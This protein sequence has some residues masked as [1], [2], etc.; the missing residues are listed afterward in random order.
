MVAAHGKQAP[1]APF[2]KSGSAIRK[3]LATMCNV[4]PDDLYAPP[5]VSPTKKASRA[6]AEG[7]GTK[8]TICTDWFL[9]HLPLRWRG[10]V[11]LV[12]HPDGIHAIGGT[13]DV[14]PWL[15]FAM[16]ATGV[17]A[18]WLVCALLV[19]TSLLPVFVHEVLRNK[20]WAWTALMAVGA[21]LGMLVRN[22]AARKTDLTLNEHS[23]LRATIDQSQARIRLILRVEGYRE[24]LLQ[25]P[26]AAQLTAIVARC[27]DDVRVGHLGAVAMWVRQWAFLLLMALGTMGLILGLRAI[28]L[29][30]LTAIPG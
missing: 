7:A 17:G 19:Q 10:T 3:K 22:G 2:H 11:Q 24:L 29:W 20:T 13:T 18:G 27:G 1:T 14:E 8:A 6:D 5:P 12:E 4:I 28:L 9:E 15:S 16:I 21:L 25:L 23:V 26:S 30:L